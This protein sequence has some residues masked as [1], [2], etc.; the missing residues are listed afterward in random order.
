M[1]APSAA[2]ASADLQ[3]SAGS[4]SASCLQRKLQGVDLWRTAFNVLKGSLIAAGQLLSSWSNEAR[5]LT[6]DWAVGVDTAGHL[7]E[8]PL[9][10]DS[11]VA[12]FLDRLEQVRCLPTWKLPGC[13]R[14][15]QLHGLHQRCSCADH[16][17]CTQRCHGSSASEIYW[18]NLA[19]IELASICC[20]A[21]CCTCL[22]GWKVNISCIRWLL[23]GLRCALEPAQRSVTHPD[24]ACSISLC[25][26][27]MPS[28]ICTKSS[29]QC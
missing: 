7:W 2:S 26:R 18:G 11:Y 15:S 12:A 22:P 25:G 14:F 29:L 17:R 1:P 16:P 5:I 20:N 4:F 19:P 23:V 28:E 8:G 6:G 3:L 10:A 13:S 9:F 27:S 24:G 21:G